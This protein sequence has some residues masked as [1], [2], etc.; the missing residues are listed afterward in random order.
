MGAARLNTIRARLDEFDCGRFSKT[1]FH[2]R[3][4]SSNSI[5]RQASS[6]EDHEAIQP[7]YTVASERERVNGELDLLMFLDRRAHHA[8]VAVGVNAAA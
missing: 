6:H 7:R 1:T 3:Y 8:I 5:P 2:P 4:P